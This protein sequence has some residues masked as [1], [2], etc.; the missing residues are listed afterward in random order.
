[1]DSYPCRRLCRDLKKNHH[2]YPPPTL[3]ANG[4]KPS[5]PG[6][7]P[8]GIGY[9]LSVM[10]YKASAIGYKPS[11]T[12]YKLS[13]VRYKLSGMGYNLSVIGH[14]LSGESYKPPGG[15]SIKGFG[16][17]WGKG[18]DLGR[19]VGDNTNKG[20]KRYK[21][22][23]RKHT[24]YRC[25]RVKFKSMALYKFTITFIFTCWTLFAFA[26]KETWT[27]DEALYYKTAV[28]LCTYLSSHEYDT[29]KRDFIFENY[30]YFD[31]AL[32]DTSATRIKNRI[33]Y[34]DKLFPV[35]KHFV[36]S[37]GLANL[38]AKPV[39]FFSHDSEFYKPFTEEIK[40]L[41]SVTLAYFDKRRPDKPIGTLLFE[42]KT[43]KLVA[44][45]LI[46]QGGYHYF[47]TFNLVGNK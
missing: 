17:F 22:Q 16:W 36:D 14:K 12:G 39:R 1:M 38:D 41:D 6:Y 37:M 5:V 30:V 7:K 26:Q 9:K 43:H 29:S 2:L 34:F 40:D 33:N 21:R 47:L 25:A 11:E 28:E 46:N 4:Y 8:S 35:I 13:E 18:V 10:G 45:I 20:L 3:S 32:S 44:W 24:H 42:P 19:L 23:I 15:Y 31:Y 27:K